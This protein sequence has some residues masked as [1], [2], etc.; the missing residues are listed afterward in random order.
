MKQ[1]HRYRMDFTGKWVKASASFMGLSVF[2]LAVWY[3]GFCNLQDFG[4]GAL[5]M[6]L[7]IPFILGA[8]YI[9]LMQVLRWNAPGVYAILGAMFCAI[10]ILGLFSSGDMLRILLG[11]AGYAF[12]AVI[13]VA[14]VGG[15]L[16]DKLIAPVVFAI[17]IGVRVLCFDVHTLSGLEWIEESATICSQAALLCLP[18]GLKNAKRKELP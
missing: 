14:V 5:V 8:V 16:P 7:W 10:Y 4:L 6:G 1:Y 9:L 13:L 3:F 11:T 15:Y 17:V 18:M 12:S 2:A